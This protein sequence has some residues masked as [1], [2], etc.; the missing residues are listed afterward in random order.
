MIK[1]KNLGIYIHVPFCVKKCSYCDFYSIEDRRYD[2]YLD[3]LIKEIKNSKN[4]DMAVDSIYLGGGTPSLLDPV[5]IGSVLEVIYG[6]FNVLDDCEISL[7]VNPGTMSKPYFSKIIKTG[8]N[9]INIGIQSFS[10]DNLRLLGRIHN[11]DNALKTF[12]NFRE[13][14]FK[15][16]G[17]DLIFALPNQDEKR[18]L[19]DLKYALYLKPEHISAYMLT[20]EKGTKFYDMVDEKIIS[21][22]LEDDQAKFFK[23]VNSYLA[24]NGYLF[25]E[26]SNYARDKRYISRHNYKYWAG[27]RYLG[28]GPSAHSFVHPVRWANPS[29]FDI[30]KDNV[31]NKKENNLFK[32]KL[33]KEMEEMEFFFLSFRTA[34]GLSLSR[35]RQIF[36]KDFKVKFNDLI[37]AFKGDGLIKEEGGYISLS[38]NGFL[39][40]DQIVSKFCEYA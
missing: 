35:Y 23:L 7:E 29:D 19:D 20:I 25:Y 40:M 32:E 6:E 30:W 12:E 5:K 26:V 9:R 13:A 3:I 27:N 21:T 15:N 37:E 11:K 28:F 24:E 38:I 17:I 31:L 39:L 34:K 14:G 36:G 33:N 8:V 2:E 22:P 10:D 16:I 18:L 4:R 1:R